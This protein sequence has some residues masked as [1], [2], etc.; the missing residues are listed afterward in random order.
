ML[1]SKIP[2]YYLACMLLTYKNFFEPKSAI[3][4]YIKEKGYKCIFIPK[5]YYCYS[6]GILCH[7]VTC[8]S[9]ASI[10]G[11]KRQNSSICTNRPFVNN[12]FFL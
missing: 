10:G 12:F 7:V 5:F 2:F 11:V 3:I 8:T 4:I 6:S 9:V 1:I